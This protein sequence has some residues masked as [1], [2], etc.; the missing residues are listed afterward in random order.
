MSLVAHLVGIIEHQGT[1]DDQCELCNLAIATAQAEDALTYP[2][3]PNIN[4]RVSPPD[5]PVLPEGD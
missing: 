2:G 5:N 3:A 4:L 1:L